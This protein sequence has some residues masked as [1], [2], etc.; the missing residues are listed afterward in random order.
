MCF[1]EVS[2]VVCDVMSEEV[3]DEIEHEADD[4]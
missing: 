1:D 4:G 2:G 3:D